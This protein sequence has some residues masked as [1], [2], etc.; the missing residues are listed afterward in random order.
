MTTSSLGASPYLRLFR[1]RSFA[2]LW[3]GQMVS[4]I[5]DYFNWLAI[6]I[7]I[8]RLT[9]SATMVGLSMIATALPALL[10]GPLA[11][12]F[13][14]RWDRKWTMIGSD[15]LRA[16]LVLVLLTV[17]SREQ[18]W[19]FYVVGFLVSCTSQFFFPARGAVLPLVVKEPEDWLPANGLMQIIMTV[20][21]LAGP[22]LAG[23]SIGLWGE[24]VAFVMNSAGYLVSAAAVLTM[25]VPRTT[26]SPASA[27]SVRAV[28]NDLREGVV[29]L[30]GHSS[31]VGALICM[32]VALLGAGA[33]NVVWVPFLQRTFNIGAVGLG[34]VDSAQGVGMVVGGLLLG[35]VSRRIP[36][37][38]LGAGGMIVLSIPFAMIG[39]VPLFWMVVVLSFFIGVGL[40]PLQSALTTILQMSV[41]DKK[42][43]RVG[44]SFNAVTTAA[45]LISMG[46]AATFGEMIGLRTV[47][48]LTGILI[49]LAGLIGFKLLKE[50]DH[51][52]EDSDSDEVPRFNQPTVSMIADPAGSLKAG[53]D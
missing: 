11:G 6:P 10:L 30:F 53:E 31:T 16:L 51:I 47:Y 19:I 1:N 18:V 46:L 27:N 21:L 41:P 44:A 42:R 12:V 39:Y 14:D 40:V 8:N 50:P 26:S 3:L 7:L 35:L 33:I 23:F 28:W 2:A 45:S 15:L 32:S 5:G 49:F 25:T 4:F 9:G 48:L 34:I 36:K 17:H 20:G 29:Y 43:G 37:A 38:I 22:A 24:R 13:V 52:A